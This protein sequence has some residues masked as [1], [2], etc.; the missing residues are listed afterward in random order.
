MKRELV[1]LI[2]LT[3]WLALC[4]LSAVAQGVINGDFES[5]VLAPD[6]DALGRSVWGQ[7]AFSH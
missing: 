2:A 1:R 4:P 6:W 7:S 5:G 3:V